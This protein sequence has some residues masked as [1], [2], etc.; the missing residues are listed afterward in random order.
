M[1]N[2][3][4]SLNTV[5]S[6]FG[7]ASSG[8]RLQYYRPYTL[9]QKFH[10]AGAKHRERLLMAGNQIGTS[11]TDSVLTRFFSRRNHAVLA[12]TECLLSPR[13]RTSISFA[14]K[15]ALGHFRTNCTAA[16]IHHSITSSART[17]SDSGTVSPSALAVLRFTASSNLAGRSIGRSAGLVPPKIRPT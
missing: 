12:N 1:T 7:N 16:K 5:V 13:K 10:A 9:Q 4:Y 17:R 14:G 15:F 11:P 3:T 2:L 6:T 8:D